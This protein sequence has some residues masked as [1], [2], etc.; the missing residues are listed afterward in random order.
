MRIGHRAFDNHL[1]DFNDML[2]LVIEDAACRGDGFIW[3]PGRLV[4]W[5]YGLWSECKRLPTFFPEHAELWFDKLN[6]LAGFVVSE[7][8]DGDIA[9][10]VGAGYEFLRAE[11]LA[12]AVERWRLRWPALSIEAREDD[13]AWLQALLNAG[14]VSS[15]RVA[16]TRVYD[17]ADQA[18]APHALPP[19]CSI[20]DMA[21][22]PDY[23]A[24]CA[25][26][27]N[28]FQGSDTPT[29]A[30]LT[31][32]EHVRTSPI[33]DATLDLSVVDAAGR[34]LAA[35]EAFADY[36]HGLAEVERICTHAG[37]RRQGLAEAVVRACFQRLRARGLRKA[38]ITGLSQAANN[39]YEKLGP[40]SCS[41]WTGL[42]LSGEGAC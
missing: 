37:H 17:L 18:G 16:T 20:I 28:A 38:Y 25:L 23:R 1:S 27:V 32:R 29:E 24:K 10:L 8:G 42:E 13:A 39:L 11:I 3:Q 30:D 7:N 33:Y 9:I 5:R 14:F 15:G 22:A 40:V 6:G 36:P 26:Q 12:W 34:H 41:H 19:G 2:R 31:V 21:V 35:C 4:D